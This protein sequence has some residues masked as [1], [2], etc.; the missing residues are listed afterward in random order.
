MTPLVYVLHSGNLYGTERMALATA[1]GLAAEYDPVIFAPPGKAI[2]EARRLGFAAQPFTR[3]VELALRLRPFVGRSRRLVFMAT[4]VMHSMVLLAWNLLYRRRVAHLHLVHGGTDERL[5]YGRKRRL[6]GR[7]VR[8]VA[9]SDF[10]RERLCANGVAAPQISVV[11]NFLPDSRRRVPRRGPFGEPGLRRAVVVS[12]I[13]PIKRVDLLLDAMEAEPAL[14]RLGVRIFGG[15]WQ[16][17]ELRERA[18]RSCPNVEFAGFRADIDRELSAADLLIHLCPAEPFGLAILEAMAAAVPVLVP[19]RGGAGSLV[20]D[21]V[22]GFRFAADDARSLAARILELD[23]APPEVLNRAAA[24]G[25]AA[26][27]G[28]FSARERLNDYRRLIEAELA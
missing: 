21:G 4:G 22:S 7:P 20:T 5:S 11:E 28:R 18:R 2:E 9:V 10:V 13:D 19:D 24:G 8:F 25:L 27:D 16:L 15:G 23:T 6:N 14:G 12:R 1:E 3:P 26:L 17:E